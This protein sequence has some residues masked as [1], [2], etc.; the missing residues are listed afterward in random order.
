M[1][2]LV[3]GGTRYLSH[4]TAALAVSR[5]H[6]VTVAARGESGEPPA[7]TEFVRVD[8]ATPEGV[9]A[10]RGRDFDAVIDVARVPL[11]LATVLDA[12]GEIGHYGFVSTVSVYSEHT[13]LGGTPATTPV[14]EPT[15]PDSGDLS[16]ELYGQSKVA[17]ENLLRERFGESALIVRAGLIVGP[18][19]PGDRFGYWPWRIAQGG[20]V[21][22]PGKPADTVQWIDVLDLAAWL[23]R[24]AE[25]RIGGT[26]DGLCPPVPRGEFLTGIAAA[27]GAD[28]TF[29]WVPDAF[30]EKQEVGQWAGPESLTLWVADPDYAGH[31]ARDTTASV[32]AG[33]DIRPLA[34]TARRWSE[35]NDG[36]PAAKGGLSREREAAVLAAWRDHSA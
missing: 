19:D 34:D 12:L 8:R 27:L 6:D 3:L 14:F 21:L 13:A 32:A 24:G 16:M 25:E 22:A 18:A 11:H 17:C 36:T 10:L 1:K 5:G 26:Y 30:L 33:M 29:T 7:G 20:E 28:V 2:I 15:A 4:A 9:D 23:V 31:M 35:W